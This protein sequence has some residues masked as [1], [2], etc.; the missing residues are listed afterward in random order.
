MDTDYHIHTANS[1]GPEIH[2]IAKAAREEGLREIGLVDHCNVNPANDIGYRSSMLGD[3]TKFYGLENHFSENADLRDSALEE[4]TQDHEHVYTPDQRPSID[5]R[6]TALGM[7]ITDGGDPWEVLG[8]EETPL[9]VWRG[10]EMDYHPDAERAISGFLDDHD[11][12][13]SIG[14]VHYLDESYVPKQ[15][16]FPEMA[17][18]DAEEMTET[19]F[20]RMVSLVESEIFDVLAHPGLIERNPYFEPH[21]RRSHYEDVAETLLDSSTVTE[22]NGKSLERQE[23]PYP[24]EVMV[25]EGVR[26]LVTGTD[27][28]RAREIAERSELV[29]QEVEDLGVNPRRGEDVFPD[30]GRRQPM[31]SD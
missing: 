22:I 10:V 8:P 5:S 19:Y 13:Y 1:D 9:I 26:D 17:P 23:P 3:G 7:K 4:Y 24:V 25:D 11:F 31:L 12:D 27:T 18:A 21:V 15:E 28:H 16:N 14:S 2:R 6:R 29:D 20:D 30:S